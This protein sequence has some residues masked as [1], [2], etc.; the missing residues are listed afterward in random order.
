M[1]LKGM[2]VVEDTRLSWDSDFVGQTDN[3]TD[4]LVKVEDSLTGQMWTGVVDGHQFLDA[5][6]IG[7]SWEGEGTDDQWAGAEAIMAV[8]CADGRDALRF[9]P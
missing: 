6:A 3:M 4:L 1:T 9:I 8:I 5:V 7:I 2:V